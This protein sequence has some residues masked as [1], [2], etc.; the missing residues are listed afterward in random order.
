MMQAKTEETGDDLE[1]R[2]VSMMSKKLEISTEDFP[3]WSIYFDDCQAF[4]AP[5]EDIIELMR[6][7]PN[8]FCAGLMYGIYLMRREM[9]F[10]TER[11]F[12]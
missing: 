4:T 6:C 10:A 2:L 11:P 5:K 3:E 7:A 8:D 1:R 12:E 9:A